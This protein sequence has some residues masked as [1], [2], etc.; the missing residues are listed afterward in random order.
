MLVLVDLEEGVRMV[1]ELLDATPER[2]EIG[3]PVRGR[4][5]AVDDELTLPGL[6]AGMTTQAGDQLPAWGLPVTPTLVVSTAIATR[7]FQDVHH[8]RDLA[9]VL[10][11]EGHLPEHPDHQRPGRALRHRLGRP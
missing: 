7:D 3:V 9:H 8:D 5:S 2:V 4:D 11:V 6:E 1:G 10:R